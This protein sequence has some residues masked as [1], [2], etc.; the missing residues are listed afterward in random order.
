MHDQAREQ[1][2]ALPIEGVLALLEF[3]TAMSL[4]PWNFADP[5]QGNMPTAAFGDGRGLVTVLILDGRRELFVTKVQW[6][7]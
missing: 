7:G 3:M 4:A 2:A 5:Q 6:I 1:A